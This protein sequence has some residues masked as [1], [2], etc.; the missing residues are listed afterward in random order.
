MDLY[1]EFM[2]LIDALQ[3]AQL[4]H[5][6]C[7][8]VAMAFHGFMRFTKDIDLLILSEDLPKVLVVARQ[9]GFEFETSPMSFSA[10]TPNE[11]K[12]HRVNKVVGSDFLSL[13]LV[14]V[15]PILEDVWKGRNHYSWQGRLIQAVSVDGL[16]KMKRLA[17]RDQDRVD[18]KR[19]G[20]EDDQPT[21]RD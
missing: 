13:D 21:P 5:A 20:F 17:N 7:G 19:L 3:Q 11:M 10:G 16:A 18:L 8:G 12:I 4:E 6:V 15:S 1:T 2:E 14:V 9:R